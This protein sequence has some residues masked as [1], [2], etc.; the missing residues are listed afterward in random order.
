MLRHTP[1]EHDRT[2]HVDEVLVKLF[3]YE[4]TE[5]S[6]HTYLRYTIDFTRTAG[7]LWLHHER[8]ELLVQRKYFC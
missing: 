7:R 6:L 5:V 8:G 3:A 2:L 1:R 4:G